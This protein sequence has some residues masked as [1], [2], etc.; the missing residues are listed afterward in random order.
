MQEEDLPE[1]LTDTDDELFRHFELTADP[2]QRLVRLDQFL[3]DKMAQATRTRVQAGIASGA[4]RVNGQVVRASYRIKP[5]DHVTVSLPEPPPRHEVRPE[6]IPLD[7]RYEDDEVLVLYKPAGLV[8]HPAHG[9]WEGTLVNGLVHHLQGL[10]THR[11]GEI[12]PGLVHRIDKDTS[13]LLLIAKTDFSMSHLARQFFQHEIGRT[14]Q[15]I[16]WGEPA[17]DT[18]TITGHIGRSSRDRRVM[19]VFPDGEQGKH[20]VTHYTVRQRLRYVSLVE[21]RLET[22]RTHQIR[23]HLR[24][25]GHPL[26]NDAMYGGDR[27]VQ[28]TVFTRYRQFVENCFA[29]CPRQALH[30]KTLG[31]VHPRTGQWLEF[32]TP[33]PAD[34]QAVLDKWRNYVSH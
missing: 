25:I 15:A 34:M 24:H 1:G 33:L 9:N 20:A 6:N 12:R 22:G 14:Y 3:A 21:C 10:P 31:F 23:A 5:H 16:V 29:L 8:V 18:G 7:I 26:F 13:G 28:G 19:D 17:A 32:D 11:N 4:V 30:A 27:I 2:G